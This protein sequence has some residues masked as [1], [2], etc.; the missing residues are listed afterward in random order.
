VTG[1]IFAII[2]T[3]TI[4]AQNWIAAMRFCM[5]MAGFAGRYKFIWEK[6]VRTAP[7][8]VCCCVS[9]LIS[10]GRLS[11][12]GAKTHLEFNTNCLSKK[13]ACIDVLS[14][15][16]FIITALSRGPFDDAQLLTCAIN[17]AWHFMEW[18]AV[19]QCHIS[20]KVCSACRIANRRFV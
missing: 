3:A 11:R 18:R 17:G 10:A 6:L 4:S 20:R 14:K 16:K 2:C 19:R 15:R 5:D 7:V 9:E 13:S 1:S 8:E 12:P